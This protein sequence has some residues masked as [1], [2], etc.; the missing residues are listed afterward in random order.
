MQQSI[1]PS[2]LPQEKSLHL[3]RPASPT[4]PPALANTFIHN[5]PPPYRDTS[6]PS[7]P[8]KHQVSIA[9]SAILCKQKTP[10]S[11]HICVE[12]ARSRSRSQPPT[13]LSGTV[14]VAPAV[15]KHAS[16]NS[17]AS[18]ERCFWGVWILEKG[19]CRRGIKRRQ[20]AIVAGVRG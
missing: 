12:D 9:I 7:Q 5:P 15:S 10:L 11:Q 3:T 8:Q 1:V 20:W 6:I 2:F 14:D 18:A 4:S 13:R 19:S 17:N 16:T